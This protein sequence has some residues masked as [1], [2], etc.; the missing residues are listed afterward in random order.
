MAPVTGETIAHYRI[1]EKLGE[2][3]MGEVY[4]A[5]DERLH[6]S[7]AI[8]FSKQGFNQR[9]SRE[10]TTIASLNHPN[11]CS[12]YDIGDFQGEEFL[13]MEFV[14]GA[15]LPVPVPVETA[16]EYAVQIADAL[17]AAHEKG[18]IHRDLKPA[19]ILVTAA[20]HIKVL[21]FGIAKHVQ[22]SA[23]E[24]EEAATAAATGDLSLT[25]AG[26]MVGTAAYMSPEQVEGKPVN[27]RSDIFSFGSV[28]YFILNW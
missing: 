14:E 7:V 18:I 3:G 20:G 13:V 22:L 21:D 11:I 15:R 25:T 4:K 9:F 17:E 1:L 10:A 6:R 23:P 5:L 26:V 19:N 2:G 8:K 16:L 27:A 12:L 24:G 28:L